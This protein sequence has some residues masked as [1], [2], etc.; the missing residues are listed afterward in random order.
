METERDLPLA[1]QQSDDFK[2]LTTAEAKGFQTRLRFIEEC[3]QEM[4]LWLSGA[5][6]G[7]RSLRDLINDVELDLSVCQSVPAK[8]QGV[9]SWLVH[10]SWTFET[11]NPLNQELS[12]DLR[13]GIDQDSPHVGSD[14]EALRQWLEEECATLRA[15]LDGFY[16]ASTASRAVAHLVAMNSIVAA[17]LFG[18]YRARL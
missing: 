16:A 2:D 14:E 15:A 5:E 13:K 18:F 3:L 9:S 12:L 11:S 10:T 6:T 1:L 8:G 4:E 17:L 7:G